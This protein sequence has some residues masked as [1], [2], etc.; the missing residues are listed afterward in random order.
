M[1]IIITIHQNDK[2]D[3]RRESRKTFRS[4]LFLLAVTR[5]ETRGRRACRRVSFCFHDEEYLLVFRSL[6]SATSIDLSLH[7]VSLF[8]SVDIRQ[9]GEDLASIQSIEVIKKASV[10]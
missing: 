4:L 6:L 8:I 5:T 1:I 3:G 10:I 2:H 7:L 9:E